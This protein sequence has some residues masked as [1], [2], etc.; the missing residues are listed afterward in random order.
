MQSETNIDYYTRRVQRSFRIEDVSDVWAYGPRL[1]ELS[2]FQSGVDGACQCH[3][4]RRIATEFNLQVSPV[5]VLS[6][7]GGKV[8][9]ISS[10][11]LRPALNSSVFE[12]HGSRGLRFQ[13]TVA[14]LVHAVDLRPTRRVEYAD[15]LTLDEVLPDIRWDGSGCFDLVLSSHSTLAD[16]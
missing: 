15:V 3:D 8:T 16:R 6:P 12:D 5:G 4:N 13:F 9:F 1:L 10:L 11:R 14:E 2:R 7:Q